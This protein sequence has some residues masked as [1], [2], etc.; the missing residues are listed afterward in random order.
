MDLNTVC[1]PL[2]HIQT[3]FDMRKSIVLDADW[4]QR[5][6]GISVSNSH[7]ILESIIG[8]DQQD[9]YRNAGIDYQPGET[10]C[11]ISTRQVLLLVDQAIRALDMPYLGLAMG[12]LMTI[13][14]HGMAG[15]AAVT[16][17]TLRDCI[18]VVCRFCTELF[19][20]LEM[21]AHIEGS[22]GMLIINENLSLAPYSHFF[23]ELNMVSFYNIF[24]QL[25]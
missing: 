6:A 11:F 16:Q 13:S 14:H 12:N 24:L 2:G 20:A 10:G 3:Y 15:V 9:F 23:H 4:L 25:V 19:P 17:T 18:E 1:I 5:R 22:E 8:L 21:S 7:E